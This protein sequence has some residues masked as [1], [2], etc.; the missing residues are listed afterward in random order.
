MFLLWHCLTHVITQTTKFCFQIFREILRESFENKDRI[1]HWLDFAKHSF[2]GTFADDAVD[3]TKS[4]FKVS[5]LF[6]SFIPYWV[7]NAQVMNVFNK[8]MNYF[9]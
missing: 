9:P 8:S 7:T 5:L 1:Q 3:Q 4:F 2:G 6:L